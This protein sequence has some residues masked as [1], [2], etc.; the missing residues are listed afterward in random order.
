MRRIATGLL[1]LMSALF[2]GVRVLPPE[3]ASWSSFVG[4]F[5]EAAMIGALA[6]WFAVTAL[7]RHPLGLPIPHTAIIPRNKDR[8][9]ANLADFL[10]HNFMTHEVLREELGRVDFAG[11]AAR[12]LQE[13]QNSRSVARQLGNAVPAFLRMV[14]DEEATRFM[15]SVLG[16]AVRDMKLAPML[17]GVLTVLVHGRQHILLLER[18]LGLVARALEQNRPYIRQ[19]VH[20]HSPRWL[21]KAVDEKFYARL[22]AGVQSVLLEIQAEDS[23]W[24]QRFE[25]ATNEL[26]DKL[27]NSPEYEQKL[28]AMLGNSLGHPLFRSY[29]GDVWRDVRQR[30]LADIESPDSSV[31]R[32]IDGIIATLGRALA[33]DPAIRDRINTWLRAF[34]ADVIVERRGAIA[35][36][37]RRV[38]EKWDADTV[39][40]KL[41]LQ[42]GSDLQFIR[43]N[44]TIVGGAVGLLLH[45]VSL[46]I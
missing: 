3:H 10:Q 46:A 24:R 42:V 18:F 31:V 27:A 20:E 21:P 43:I 28:H 32:R 39:A 41:E 7:F 15:R 37:A 9:G 14:G 25:D 33:R 35:A 26:I 29:V 19:K 40:R 23:E 5:A 2:V 30:M 1:V 44:G 22:M 12:W 6:D 17:A 34:A 8:I 11:T 13:K 16:D 45:A 4:A 36:L 38:I